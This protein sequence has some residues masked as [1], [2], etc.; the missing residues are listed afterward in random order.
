MIITEIVLILLSFL[1]SFT[2]L[3][4]VTSGFSELLS[5]FVQMNDSDVKKIRKFTNYTK[6]LFTH[7][8]YKYERMGDSQS[9]MSSSASFDL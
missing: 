2:R 5:I 4:K 1:F 6:N 9:G 3:L 8:K 7:L